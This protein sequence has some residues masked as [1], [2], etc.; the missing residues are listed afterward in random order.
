MAD[1][2][3][4]HLVRIV[5]DDFGWRLMPAVLRRIVAFCAKYPTEMNP[6]QTTTTVKGLF[7]ADDPRLGLWVVT[8]ADEH[9]SAHCFAIAGGSA[10]FLYQLEIDTLLPSALRRAAMDAV[11]QWARDCGA[12][13]ID[14]STWHTAR[15][16]RAYG[17]VPHRTIMRRPL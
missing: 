16:W 13:H 10:A 1:N 8:D 14:A 17:F 3:A 5:G 12:T 2:S 6:Q 7:L 9:I 15:L 4:R 11:D